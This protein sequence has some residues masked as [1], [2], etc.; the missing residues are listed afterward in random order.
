MAS[1]FQW[2]LAIQLTKYTV[3]SQGRLVVDR[4]LLF[5]EMILWFPGVLREV[6]NEPCGMTGRSSSH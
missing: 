6:S 4:L 3:F 5:L 2:Y 1:A